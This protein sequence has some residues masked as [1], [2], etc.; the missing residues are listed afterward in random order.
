MLCHVIPYHSIPVSRIS[1]IIIMWFYTMYH[2]IPLHTTP[3]HAHPNPYHTMTCPCLAPAKPCLALPMPYHITPSSPG[4]HEQGKAWH[5]M[6]G[7]GQG[8]AWQECPCDPRE[9]GVIWYGMGKAKHGM[10]GHGMGKAWYG[11]AWYGMVRC[12]MVWG[13]LLG[14]LAILEIPRKIR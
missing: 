3:Q 11:M 4:S 12:G 1:R 10:S 7:H 13:H 8:K 14:T 2:P 6:A 9:D 5:G